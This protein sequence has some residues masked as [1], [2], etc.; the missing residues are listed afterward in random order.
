MLVTLLPIV[1]LVRLVQDRTRSPDGGD[2][3]GIVTLVRLVQLE[4]AD[5]DAGDQQAID[6]AGDGHVTAGT[7]VSGDGDRAVIG[8]VSVWHGGSH[9]T[10][11]G[12]LTLLSQFVVPGK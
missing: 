7:G 6:H 1:T 9:S 2:V 8:R 5:P 11:G 4:N 12:R 10:A 3:L